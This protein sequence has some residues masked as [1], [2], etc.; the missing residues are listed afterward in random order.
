VRDA[1]EYLA[2]PRLAGQPGARFSE[3]VPLVVVPTTA[4]TGSEASPDAGIHPTATTRS[5]GMSSEDLI[6]NVAILDPGL[7]LSPSPRL[8]AATAIDALSHCVE[9]YFSRRRSP[10]VDALL[11]DGIR[12]VG[13]ALPAAFAD[14]S[15]LEARAELMLAAFAGGVG[16]GMGLGP[17]HA[18][19]IACR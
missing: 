12:P 7:T 2:V 13:R 6:P 3:R 16:I 9:G 1:A 14:G 8:T 5:V 10:L 15:N 19:A 17:A 11:L 18:I 4:G